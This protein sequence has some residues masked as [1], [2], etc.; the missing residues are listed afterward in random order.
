MKPASF[1]RRVFFWN[2]KLHIWCGLFLLIFTAVFS[3]SGLLLNHSSWKLTSFW[4]QRKI[5]EISTPVTVPELPDNNAM[6]TKFMDQLDIQG[7]VSNI[8][9]VPGGIDFRIT[10]PGT[11]RDVHID[12]ANKL[13]IQ[14]LTK[15]NL[16]GTLRTLHTFNGANKAD[17]G[18]RPG[19]IVTRIW[20]LTMDVIAIGL[21]FLSL[22]GWLMWYKK[23][24]HADIPDLG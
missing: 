16:W 4:D 11:I 23:T 14:K 7:E 10:V 20:L 19:W 13:S 22:S 15:Y 8:K 12:Y 5:S 6:V 17:P 3:I 2:R 24:D 9:P 21:I 18:I 1:K